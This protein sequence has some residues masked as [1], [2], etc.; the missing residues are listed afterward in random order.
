[1]YSQLLLLIVDDSLNPVF[2]I[3]SCLIVVLKYL[4]PQHTTHK[5]IAK[6]NVFTDS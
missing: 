3:I 4:G 2:G 5:A 1:M 6:L